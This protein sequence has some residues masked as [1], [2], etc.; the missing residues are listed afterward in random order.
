MHVLGDTLAK[1]AA[2]K[3][4]IIHDHNRVFMYKQSTEIM[5]PIRAWARKHQA[6]LRLFDERAERRVWKSKLADM[7]DYQQRNWLLAYGAYRYLEE[8]DGL[9]NLD[10]K[11]LHGS[12]AVRIPG[13]MD[14]AEVKGK[15]VV[16]DGA[17]NAQK[18]TA[19]ISSFQRLYPGVKP[20]V[21]LGL[22]D[23]KDYEHLVPLLKPFASR[24]IITAFETSQDSF[25]QS[26]DPQILGK[27]F[28]QAG[29]AEVQV[30]QDRNEAFKTLL[31]SP[32]E[33]CLITGSFYL[34]NQLRNNRKR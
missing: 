3:A 4:G 25:V 6:H 22:R 19:C 10:D 27:A 24:V 15:T 1:I 2:Q 23:N 5:R 16:M 33:V 26:M 32:E 14:I 21:L 28:K 11:T 20:A 7:A 17:H 34:L 12:Q 8:R 9:K 29:A 13:R 30:I 18:M 31:E